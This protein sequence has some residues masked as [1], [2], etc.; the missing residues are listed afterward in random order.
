MIKFIVDLRGL[1]RFKKTPGA[2]AMS[3]TDIMS[4]VKNMT[5]AKDVFRKMTNTTQYA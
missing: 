4:D 5:N 3:S 2:D 1:K